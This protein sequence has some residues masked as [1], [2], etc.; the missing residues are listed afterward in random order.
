LKIDLKYI[1]F[2]IPGLLFFPCFSQNTEFHLA[3]AG[4]QLFAGNVQAYGLKEDGKKT[5]LLVYRLNPLLGASDSLLIDQGKS[6]T[7]DFLQISS[8]TLHGFLNIYLQK[9]E[10]KLVQ[11]YRFNKNFKLIAAIEDAEVARLNSISTFESEVFYHQS[12]VFTVKAV[13]D[14]SGRQFYLNK[15]SLKSALKNF[16][17]ELKWQF[18]FERKNIH[19]AHTLFAN[20]AYV[21]LYVNVIDGPKRGQWLLKIKNETGQL[22]RGTKLNAKGDLSFYAFGGILVDSLSNT[23]YVQGQ[24]FTEAELDQ[25]LNKIN[26]A[27][28][29]HCT[30][31]L[32]QMDSTGELLSREEFKIPVVEAKGVT[33]K[34]AVSY[35]LQSKNFSKNKEGIFTIESDLFKGSGQQLCFLYCNSLLLRIAPAEDKLVLEKTSIGANPLVEKYYLNNDKLDMNGKLC[36]DSIGEFEKIFYKK[37]TFGVKLAYKLDDANNPVWLLQKTETK[38]NNDN[39]SLLAPVKKIYQ[40]TKITDLSGSENSAA[41]ILSNKQ[42]IIARQSLPDRFQLQLLNW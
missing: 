20:K 35:L 1:L 11:V 27:G 12:S 17:Y 8:D 37:L 18:A 3:R 13:S 30:V 41:V 26:L 36:I 16:E 19:S 9:K 29:P 32:A 24:K 2:A 22:V 5:F 10:K 23:I 4:A 14:T 28:K 21:L 33:N 7:D 31:Y 6:K 39:Y 15:Y 34:I 40:L 25:K 42:F 38:K